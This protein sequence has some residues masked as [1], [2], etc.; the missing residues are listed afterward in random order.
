MS[1]M[2]FKVG[3][4]KTLKLAFDEPKVGTN[5]YGRWYMYGF[6]NGDLSSEEDCFFATETLHSMIK[7]LGAGE[8]DEITIEKCNDGEITFFK[9]NGLSMDDM[10]KGQLRGGSAEKIET[11]KPKMSYDELLDKYNHLKDAYDQLKADDEIPY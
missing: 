7:S 3:E 6:K 4:S 10:N 9:V 5:S 1:A 8:G 2:K 11:V